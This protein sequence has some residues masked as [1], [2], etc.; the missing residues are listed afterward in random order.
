M[1]VVVVVMVELVVG[2][3]WRWWCRWGGCGGGDG[4]VVWW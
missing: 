2:M 3:R 4:M 1:E